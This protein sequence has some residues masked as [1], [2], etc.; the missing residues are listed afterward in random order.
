[1]RIRSA[2]VSCATVLWLV[3]SAAADAGE[4]YI[5]AHSCLPVT[6]DDVK[7]IFLGERQMIDG[8]NLVLVDNEA[9]QTA[10][11]DKFIKLSKARYEEIW[12]KKA[13]QEGLAIPKSKLDDIE[14]VQFVK[15][16]PGA[17]SYMTS[18]PLFFQLTKIC[19]RSNVFSPIP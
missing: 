4:M 19:P 5:V 11:L 3:C 7:S 9:S 1:M 15:R 17:I 10:F 14:V 16:T 18:S 2:V 6:N 12:T 13:F 8:V